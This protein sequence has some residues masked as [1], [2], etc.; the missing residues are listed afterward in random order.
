MYFE[1]ID[2]SLY[3]DNS[4]VQEPIDEHEVGYDHIFSIVT[5]AYYGKTAEIKKI[6]DKV[7]EIRT[8]YA[9]DQMKANTAKEKEELEDLFC[10]AFGFT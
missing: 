1:M 6:E 5:E 3:N 9:T 2:E 4:I 10:D 7:G 8:R